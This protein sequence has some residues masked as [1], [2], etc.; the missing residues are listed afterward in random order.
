[1]RFERQIIS[2][3]EG[4]E[5]VACRWLMSMEAAMP[6]AGDVAPAGKSRAAVGFEKG[7]NSRPLTMLGGLVVVADFPAIGAPRVRFGQERF[8]GCW[9]R[10][11]E[12]AF[13]GALFGAGQMVEARRK[14]REAEA[15]GSGGAIARF[16][17]P[18][19]ARFRR[20]RRFP[21]PGGRRALSTALQQ[22]GGSEASAAGGNA[23][24]REGASRRTTSSGGVK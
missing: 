13:Q 5:N 20:C 22:V 10:G 14:K 12:I 4:C 7:R 1:M 17:I 2:F 8:A 23:A 9:R 24:L 3:R 19:V 6:L 15:S 11:E 21:D 18:A 16:S